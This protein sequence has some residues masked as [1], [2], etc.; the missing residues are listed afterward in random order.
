MIEEKYWDSCKLFY[1]MPFSFTGLDLRETMSMD[2]YK[3]ISNVMP[4]AVV[5]LTWT[6]ITEKNILNNSY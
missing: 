5:S 1:L 6:C 3:E 2:M 4:G